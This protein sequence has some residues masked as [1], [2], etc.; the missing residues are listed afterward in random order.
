MLPLLAF[1]VIVGGL[2]L[3]GVMDADEPQTAPTTNDGQPWRIGYLEG[4]P[5]VE[6][7]RSLHALVAGLVELGW[8]E[9]IDL[10]ERTEDSRAVWQYLSEH[11]QSEYLEFVADAWYSADWDK[12]RRAEIRDELLQRLNDSGDI[13]F[14]IAMG[15]SAG[16]DLRDGHSTPTMVVSTT[17]PVA[18]GIIDS[19]EDSGRDYLHAKCDPYRYIRQAHAFHNLVQFDRL[20]VIAGKSP[21]GL[22]YA[23]VPDLQHVAARCGFEVV[24][25]HVPDSDI[26]AEE[27]SVLARQAIGD[28]A[29]HVDAF[30]ITDHLG[31]QPR[32]LPDVIQPLLEHR[33][34]TWATQG[35][36]QVR[37]GALMGI[38]E[39]NIEEVGLF[40][41]QVMARILNGESPRDIEQVHEDP[42]TLVINHET[43]RRIGYAVPPSMGRAVDR[44]YET[45]EGE[46]PR[47][48]QED[49]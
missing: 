27:A 6:Y 40:H 20:G 13:D 36:R 46:D 31:T 42:K 2:L 7:P 10:P 11:A 48:V 35:P 26:A 4:G 12:Q 29:P 24:V 8:M 41:A 1:L 39:R 47:L 44:V 38:T 14:M 9:P 32:F 30:W 15:T 19:P 21:T 22:I 17:D 18:A 5:Y 33:V 45:I 43:A 16:Q 25:V 28:L 34:A 3:Y 49:R 37:R 23:N